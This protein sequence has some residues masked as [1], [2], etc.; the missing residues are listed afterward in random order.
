MTMPPKQLAGPLSDGG[1][2]L[3]ESGPRSRMNY[4]RRLGKMAR[5][6][7]GLTEGQKKKMPGCQ[8][9]YVGKVSPKVM[10]CVIRIPGKQNRRSRRHVPRASPADDVGRLGKQ[11]GNRNDEA[12][13]P[14]SPCQLRVRR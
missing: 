8:P 3:A 7:V 12:E 14:D 1:C 2:G 5:K 9:R 13:R 10:L 4:F 11:I 6:F